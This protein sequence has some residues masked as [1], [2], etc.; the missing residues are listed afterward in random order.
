MLILGAVRDPYEVLGVGRNASEGEIR[1][2]FRRRA[3]QHH[4][5]RNPNDNGAQERFKEL[6]Q[7]YQILSD[8]QKRAAWDR[9]GEAAFAPGGV[10]AGPG[11]G[12]ADIGLDGIF[13]DILGAFG[14]RGGDRNVI[15]KK[16][17]ISFEE[18]AHGCEKSLTYEVMDGCGTCRGSG[19]EPGTAVE[20]CSACAGRGRVRFQQG[21]LPIAVE[22]PCSR[23]RGAG[24]MPTSPCARCGGSGLIQVS[25]TRSIDIP[26]GIESGASRVVEGA[27]HRVR[28]DAPPGSLEV[29][30]EVEPHPFFKR[31]GDDVVCH[32][33]IT[34]A[35]AAL[36]GEVEV[37]TL[38]GKVR[39]RIPPA[40]QPGTVL[41][42]RGKG[43]AHR[44]RGGHGDQLV[45]V[46]VEIP[47]A[48]S[49]RAKEL[50]GELAGELGE[51]VQPQQKTFVEKLKSL[52]G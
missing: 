17:R 10:G 36:G 38:S 18:A 23:C 20:T 44:L 6:N 48:L 45:E 40:T 46:S 50:I 39:L 41:R 3:A 27:G 13:G 34:F 11:V 37:P 31:D 16:L 22:R 14:F 35:Q 43:I 21:I 26:P 47:T 33:P 51:D 30:V 19:A 2:A 28:A 8:A 9:F 25:R 15:R 42:I 7:A 32:V 52:F 24:R 5:D 4:P 12:F 49:D 29:V 1:T